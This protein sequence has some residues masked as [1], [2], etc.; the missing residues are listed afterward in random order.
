[1][2]S[3]GFG[4]EEEAFEYA[5]IL[6]ADCE[7]EECKAIPLNEAQ[8]AGLVVLVTP[9]TFSVGP[10][11]SLCSRRSSARSIDVQNPLQDQEE[12]PRAVSQRFDAPA[13]DMRSG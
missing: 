2:K 7:G 9:R 6:N 4:T 1:M 11:P 12:P 8:A 10:N 3:F 13:I 5:A